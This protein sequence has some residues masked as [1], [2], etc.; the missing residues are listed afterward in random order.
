[1]AK[2]QATRVSDQLRRIIDDCGLSHSEIVE[3][4]GIDK[5]TLSKFM[6]GERGLSMK[7]LDRLGQC[8]G[9][10]VNMRRKRTK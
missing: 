6:H 8:L 3:Q 5:G 4:T 9:L 2:Q 7:A 10:T 1:M